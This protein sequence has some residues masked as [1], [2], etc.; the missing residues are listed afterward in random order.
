V[1]EDKKHIISK[2]MQ[3]MMEHSCVLICHQT[4]M[5]GLHVCLYLYIISL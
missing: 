5:C 3:D 1:L 2:I 4:I